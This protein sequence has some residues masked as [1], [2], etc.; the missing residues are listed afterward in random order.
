MSAATPSQTITATRSHV[1]AAG[2]NYAALTITVMVASNAPTS[3]TNTATVT[4]DGTGT[5]TDTG[6]GTGSG[7]GSG[8]GPITF[9]D[10]GDPTPPPPPV[11]DITPIDFSGVVYDDR[12][13]DGIRDH[14]DK[15]KPAATQGRKANGSGFQMAGPPNVVESRTLSKRRSSPH[16]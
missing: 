14:N 12:D 13:G 11:G 5:G 16:T 8:D 4:G 1:L 2:G 9:P 6:G 3:I 10:P 7:T 15:G